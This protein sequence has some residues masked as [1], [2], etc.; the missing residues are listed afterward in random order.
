[1]KKALAIIFTLI[2][3]AVI[4]TVLLRNRSSREAKAKS[5]GILTVFPVNTFTVSR[6]KFDE[7]LEMLGTVYANKEVLVVSETQGRITELNADVGTR[8]NAGTQLAKVDDELKSAALLSADANFE[9]AK[10]DL[11]R[12][13]QL[14]KEK[15]ISG[16]QIDAVRF[17]YKAAESQHII[18]KRQLSDTK[19]L[20][21][22]SGV[23]SSRL[24][25]VGSF[26]NIG[27]PVMNIVDI[28]T[29]KI[30]LN[31]GE[32]DVFKL[33]V[34]DIVEIQTDVYQN[35]TFHGKISNISDK[36]Y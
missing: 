32:K 21:P 22:I 7:N 11:Q 26:L 19:I 28:S 20:S 5:T 16:S 27:A 34:G 31:V 9:K 35:E 10:S 23:V 4:V 15:S 24:I 25:E 18:A 13:E 2:L 1:M 29:L 30:K 36:S 33:K 6:Q 14:F 17:A 3:A 8:V 12:N